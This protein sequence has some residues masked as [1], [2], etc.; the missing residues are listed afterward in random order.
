MGGVPIVGAIVDLQAMAAAVHAQH[1]LSATI[2]HGVTLKRKCSLA[3]SVGN[4]VALL[5]TEKEAIVVIIA[6]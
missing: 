2:Q 4:C 6:Y 1:P 5:F 3:G